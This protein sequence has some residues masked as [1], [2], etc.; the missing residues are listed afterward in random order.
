LTISPGSAGFDLRGSELPAGNALLLL[1]LD[2][3]QA[4]RRLLAIA[5]TIADGRLEERL[6][7]EGPP[8]AA[9]I[10]RIRLLRYD[11]VQSFPAPG[12]SG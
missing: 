10:H 2:R 11:C 7:V 6:V 4:G 9:G 1:Y 12:R 5:T 8:Q 3:G